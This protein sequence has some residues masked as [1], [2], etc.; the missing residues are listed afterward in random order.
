MSGS[1]E[2]PKGEAFGLHWHRFEMDAAR[3]IVPEK[4][5][6]T[7][8]LSPRRIMRMLW[9]YPSLRAMA[10][11][12]VASLARD[13]GVRVVPLLIQQRLLTRYGLEIGP[14]A[15]I[16]GGLYIAHP[17]G[18]TLVAERIG[19]NVTI[20][21]ATTFGYKVGRGWPTI[22]DRAYF[23]V[24]A[25]VLGRIDIGD[26]AAVGANAVVVGDVAD[27]VAVVGVPAR[28]IGDSPAIRK[29]RS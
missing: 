8:E 3:W 17:V 18:C 12:R 13:L 21:G 23:G 16:G 25:R 22:G 15:D 29:A 2:K 20:I 7:D 6:S 9:L 1:S 19:E 28:P 5:G 4:I 24:G 26:D 27:G 14:G 10:W 11:F